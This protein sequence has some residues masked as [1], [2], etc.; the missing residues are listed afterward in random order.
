MMD[1]F[2]CRSFLCHSFPK[3]HVPLLATR[4]APALLQRH[5]QRSRPSSLAARPDR[6]PQRRHRRRCVVVCAFV[7]SHAFCAFCAFSFSFPSCA[8]SSSP[9]SPASASSPSSFSAVAVPPRPRWKIAPSSQIFLCLSRACL[10][11][12]IAFSIKWCNAVPA[13]FSYLLEELDSSEL[14]LL[15]SSEDDDDEKSAARAV[16]S[17]AVSGASSMACMPSLAMSLLLIGL[18]ATPPTL[19]LSGREKFSMSGQRA[20]VAGPSRRSAAL[21]AGYMAAPR[22]A[23][24]QAT[25]GVQLAHVRRPLLWV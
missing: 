14:L 19:G 13:A 12:T 11:E 15:D 2:L 18:R 17:S 20:A 23:P 21:L 8:S 10:G 22:P 24:P 3:R 1:R 16:S 25:L 6:F 7:V 5:H 4:P 9:P